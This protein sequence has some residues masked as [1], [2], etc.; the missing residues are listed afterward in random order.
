MPGVKVG[1]NSIVGPGVTL[2][3][4]LEPNKIA[5]PTRASYEV[6][7]NKLDLTGK[8]RDA[9]IKILDKA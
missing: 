8:T 4:D 1:P 5:L 7:D 6:R 2:L 3:E 9:L